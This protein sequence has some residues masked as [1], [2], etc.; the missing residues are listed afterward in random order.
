M[1]VWQTVQQM[2]D[3][4]KWLAALGFGALGGL[5]DVAMDTQFPGWW[6]I[7]RHMLLGMGPIVP[8]LLMT[9]GFNRGNGGGKA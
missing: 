2:P 6:Q 1:A 9:L 5:G 3:W 4:A 7:S 8:A